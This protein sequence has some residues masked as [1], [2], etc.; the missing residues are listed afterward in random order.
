MPHFIY[1]LTC[2]DGT[3]YVGSTTNVERRV[4]QHNAGR[5]SIHTASRRPVSLLTLRSARNLKTL[6]NASARSNGG[7]RRK[8]RP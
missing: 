7:R 1:I 4:T 3:Y 6:S 5:A 8:R 2:V